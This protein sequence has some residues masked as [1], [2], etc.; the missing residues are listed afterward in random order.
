MEEQT[1]ERAAFEFTQKQ[2][3]MDKSYHQQELQ[4]GKSREDQAGFEVALNK[5]TVSNYTSECVCRFI[6]TCDLVGVLLQSGIG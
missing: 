6:P 1:R 4:K 3:G 5:V 2:V